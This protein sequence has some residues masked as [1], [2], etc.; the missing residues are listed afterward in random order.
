MV[1]RRARCARSSPQRP[2]ARRPAAPRDPPLTPRARCSAASPSLSLWRVGELQAQINTDIV[3]AQ[4]LPT[5]A[6]KA[7]LRALLEAHVSATGSERGAAILGN[8]EVEVGK[9]WQIVPPAE[10]DRAETRVEPKVA[11][12]NVAR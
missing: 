12:A 11:A 2:G 10:A 3:S 8:F 1:R 5:Q 7:Q 6:A 4:R 9:F